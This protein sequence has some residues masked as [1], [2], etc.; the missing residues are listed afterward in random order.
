MTLSSHTNIFIQKPTDQ[1]HFDTL[2][3]YLVE[4]RIKSSIEVGGFRST[5]FQRTNGRCSEKNPR[6]AGDAS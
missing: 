5:R 3:A 6:F 4:T 2:L 1:R